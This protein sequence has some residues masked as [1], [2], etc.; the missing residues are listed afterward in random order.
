[1][2]EGYIKLAGNRSLR[3]LQAATQKK[4]E[5]VCDDARRDEEVTSLLPAFL[6]GLK[7][8]WWQ[9]V[10]QQGVIEHFVKLHGLVGGDDLQKLRLEP[11]ICERHLERCQLMDILASIQPNA[12]QR[13]HLERSDALLLKSKEF[14]T[15][16]FADSAR[17]TEFFNKQASGA[18]GLCTRWFTPVNLWIARNLL[19]MNNIISH[20]IVNQPTSKEDYS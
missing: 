2:K 11:Y 8:Y 19:E 15:L 9:A 14:D 17:D 6:I 20:I 4:W 1:M 13:L 18:K 3:E 12:L 16:F 10:Q 5:Q 7:D